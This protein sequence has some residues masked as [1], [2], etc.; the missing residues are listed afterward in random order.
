MD[1]VSELKDQGNKAL[2]DGWFEEAVHCYTDALTLDPS[3]HVL[4]SNRS[5]AHAKRGDYE[6]ALQDACNTIQIKPDWAKG[7]SRKAAALEFLGRFEEAKV[8]Y[9]EGLEHEPT[10]HQL[11]EGLHNMEAR[12]EEKKMKNPFAMP[13]MYEKLENDP[14]TRALLSDA[15]YRALLEQLR[16]KPS[17]LAMNVQDPRVMT[18]LSVLLGFDL[19][20]AEQEEPSPSSESQPKPQTPPPAEEDITENKR[21]AL[22]EKELGNAAYREKDFA[23]ALKHYEVAFRHDPTS[24]TYLANQAAV[25]FEK[26]D[27]EKCREL[28]EKAIELGRENREDYRQIAKAYARIGNS[29]FK[30]ERYLE[31]VQFY[32]KSLTE[33]RTPDVLKKCQQAEKITKEKE[34]LAY[35]DPNVALEEKNKGNEAF[36]MGDYPL[37]MKHYT[38]AIRRNPH[39]VKLFSNRAACYTKLLEFQLA[40][41]DCEDCIRLE[42]SFIKGYTRKAAALEAVKDFTKAMVFY[43]KAM[44]IDPRS[45]EAVEGLQRCLINQAARND[46]PEEVKRRAMSDPEVQQI[47]SDPAMQL[48]LEQMQKDPQA[49]NEHLKNPV[50]AQKIRKLI[51]VGTDIHPAM[52]F[53]QHSQQLLGSLR[54]QRLQGFLCDCTVQVGSS[55]F[56]AHRAIL[57]SCSPFFHM[58]FSEQPLGKTETVTIN[59]E[60]V[61]PMAFG[62]LLDFMYEG[63]LRLVTQPPPEDVLA[64]ASFL[65]MN[66]IVRVCKKRLQGRGLAEADSTKAEEECVMVGD[67]GCGIG[68]LLRGV[69]EDSGRDGIEATTGAGKTPRIQ[70]SHLHQFSPPEK[71]K[72]QQEELT[73]SNPDRFT[74]STSADVAD[75][76]QPGMDSLL[77]GDTGA[78][79]VGSG[80]AVVHPRSHSQGEST[81]GSPCSSTEVVSNNHPSSSSSSSYSL[82][83]LLNPISNSE[84][85]T[86]TITSVP[87]THTRKSSC[88]SP[89]QASLVIS[90]EEAMMLTQGTL[91]VQTPESIVIQKPTHRPNSPLPHSQ[92]LPLSPEPR[93]LH[94]VQ[95]EELVL[96]VE[97]ETKSPFENINSHNLTGTIWK[98]TEGADENDNGVKVKVE[99]III[100]DEELDDMEGMLVGESGEREQESERGGSGE[101]DDKDSQDEDLNRAQLLHPHQLHLS[102][103]QEALPFPLSPQGSNPTTSA[104]TSPTFPPSLFTSTS[105]HIPSQ[106]SHQQPIY[107]QDFQDSL[108]SYVEDV[109]TCATCGKTFSCAYTLRRHAIVHTRERPYECRYCYPQLHPVWGPVPTHSQS[110]R[111][112]PACQT[113]QTGH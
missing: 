64:A 11:K 6:S 28:C 58:F 72:Q 50:I 45:K 31:A 107:L 47:M 83:R 85:Q 77:T 104:S 8:T 110:P 103:H 30:Q 102:H 23:T 53:P 79:R 68:V 39:D 109:P 22:T 29:Y 40:L 101:F 51:D 100:S 20:R 66:D 96:G 15:G 25:Y 54:A 5:A 111:P 52:E 19:G 43:Q 93:T 105:H 99:A 82:G 84:T 70:Y 57:A 65:H 92:P 10:N 61:T 98:G 113:K 60:I 24:M 75:T 17:E 12:L 9:R 36:Q 71:A 69:G 14:R 108:G 26:G 42:P 63:T 16:K 106:E 49:L 2:S 37:A 80:C 86:V 87:V 88:T 13:N 18:T 41:K 112:Q 91:P 7:Y 48:I 27:F 46:S 97:R 73:N 3:N 89:V 62:L 38:E 35:M 34:K 67:G 33:H 59:G 94:Q 1:K 78:A 76:T 4:Y 21:Q 81:L 44:E 95:A 74:G 32:N 55:R 90:S 56:L